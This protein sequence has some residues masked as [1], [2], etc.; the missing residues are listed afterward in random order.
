MPKTL[1]QH[2]KEIGDEQTSITV[3]GTVYKCTKT[4]AVARKLFL[5]A[6]GGTERIVDEDGNEVTVI[7]KADPRVAKSIREY[8]EG[9]ASVELPKE[10]KGKAKAGQYSSETANR[11][12]DRLGAPTPNRPMRPKT[13]S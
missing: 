8:T 9:K 7:H 2:L 4:E 10:T 5:L 6:Q 1:T 3:N 13:K 11:L 12:S